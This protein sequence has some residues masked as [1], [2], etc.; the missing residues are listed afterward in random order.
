MG[1][2]LGG[3]KAGA[4][5]SLWLAG[6]VSL[7][8]ALVLVY[9]KNSTLSLLSTYSQCSA[10]GPAS[11]AGTAERCFS[12][13][14]YPGI[15]IYDFV[16]TLVIAMVFALTIGV[17]FDYIPGRAYWTRTLLASLIML[18]LMFFIGLYG[19]AADAEQE[20]LLVS[21]ELVAVLVYGVIF[22]KLYRRFTR[23]VEFQSQKTSLIKILVDRRDLTGR[24]RTFSVNS[25]HKVKAVTEGKPFKE[26]LVSGGVSVENP[27]ES[28]TK[29]KI[30]GDGLLKVA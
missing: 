17:Y 28:E 24:K 4:V 19:I 12:T 1:S 15:P 11:Q 21:F 9:F 8:N 30:V 5:G 26:W 25:T 18:I 27:K 6:S 10:L 20:A 13:L 23:E 22:A 14:L 3:A 16:R 29:I 2:V 7:F